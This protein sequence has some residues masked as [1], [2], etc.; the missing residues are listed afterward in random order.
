L[1]ALKWILWGV[2]G[3]VLLVGAVIAYVVATFDPN[4]YKPRVVE[5]VKEQTGRT[6]TIDGD[7]DLTFFP[8][9]GAKV[10][11]VALSEPNDAR[12]FAR[13]D[14]A[15][16]AVALWPLLSKRVIV[17]RVTLKGLT[18]D[19]VRYKDGRTNVDDLVGQ[20]AE[21]KGRDK[22]A[23]A[24]GGP[25]FAVDVGGITI[26]NASLG[27]RDERDGTNVR[28]SNL[29][30]ETDR[31]ASGVPGKMKLATRIE[32]AQPKVNLQLTLE[33]GYTLDFTTR[34]A[35][36]SALDLKVTGDAPGMNGLDARFKGEQ[37]DVD[38][39][40]NRVALASVEIRAKS[41]DGLDATFAVPRLQL[42][43]DKATSEAIKGNVTLATPA[44]NIAAKLEIAPLTATG[45]Q[46]QSS[47]LQIDLTAK[48]GDLG[49]QGALATP[50]TLDLERQQ[51][52][53]PRIAGDLTISGPT[54]P[55]RSMKAAV[56]GNAR[57]D[58]GA[59][60]ANAVLAVKMDDSSIDT[61]VAVAHWS[62]PAV[63]FDFVADRLDVDRYFPPAKQDAAASGGAPSGGAGAGTGSQA[64]AAAEQPFDLSPLKTLT[65]SGNVKIGALKVSNIKAEQ[66]A[67]RLDAKGGRLDI[68]PISARLYQGSLGGSASVTA[69]D[70]RFTL[71]QK[72]ASIS[73]GPLLRDAASK[74]VLEG[75]GDVVLDVTTVGATV[76]AL[77]KALAGTGKL[78]LRDGAIKG[79]DIAGTIR[80][81]K[82]LLGSKSALE[83]QAQGGAK[84]DFT[85]LTASFV[86]KNGVAH[87]EDLLMKSPLL[88]LT[89]RGDVDIGE[90]T[91]DYTAKASVVATATG[92]GGKGLGDVAGV[93][94]PVR[95]TGPLASMKYRVDVASLATDVAKDALQREL[96]RRLGGD[97][98]G[99]PSGGAGAIGDAV[100]GL[101]GR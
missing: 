75:R 65:A 56:S 84:T 20:P 94:V 80:Q 78:A 68:D 49:V 35:A 8:K 29:N 40:A 53:L 86:I 7:I 100:R 89:G 92:Q 46:V 34:A 51:A 55:N 61:K 9:I 39:A 52:Q 88:R 31:L 95:A 66:V 60:N 42:S 62:Q 85:E 71:K 10:G 76:S 99:K 37:I 97:K 1:R 27:W 14:E 45:K 79:I 24:P 96:G 21:T 33:T 22:P 67:L 90:G 73:V 18:A 32:G 28:L 93:T 81:A 57:A 59:Q 30:L 16:V 70:N 26:A 74:D 63:T 77:K 3:L 25:A 5:L 43:P 12:T 83:Q 69:S 82:A 50:I 17:D 2:A 23:P 54:I 36:L 72:L 48:A 44:R 11:K 41:K 6:L 47:G 15:R 98:G 101:F 38:P 64:G 13:I 58:W 87:N 19:L 4:D 91:I